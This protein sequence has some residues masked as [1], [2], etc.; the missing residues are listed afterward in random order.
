MNIANKLTVSRIVLALACVGF[1]LLDT[2]ASLLAA[3]FL[4]IIASLTDFFDGYLA[5]TRNLV[6]DLGKLL[7]P[8]ADKI[9]ILGVFSAFLQLGAVTVWMVVAIMLREF[10]VTGLRILGLNRGVV[11]EARKFGKHKTF[12]QAVAIVVIFIVLIGQRFFPDK[13]SINLAY[14]FVVPLIMWYVVFVTVFSGLYYLWANRKLIK[15]F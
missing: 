14:D 6:S 1:I 15:T 2:S 5:R 8:I 10:I 9:L 11:L 4:F 13:R 7:D 3:F 12:S